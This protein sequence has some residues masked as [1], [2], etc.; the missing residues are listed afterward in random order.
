MT[1][2]FRPTG[3]QTTTTI[4][5]TVPDFQFITTLD[6]LPVAAGTA[7]PVT[8]FASVP[9]PSSLAA[10]GVLSLLAVRRRRAS[11]IVQI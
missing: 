9:E 10:V 1:Y 8:S 6:G 11:S 5:G 2:T 7:G 4:T 3:L